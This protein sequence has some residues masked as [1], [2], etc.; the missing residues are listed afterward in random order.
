MKPEEIKTRELD[1]KLQ[2]AAVLKILSSADVKRPKVEDFDGVY[3]TKDI[4]IDKEYVRTRKMRF[5]RD[6]DARSAEEADELAYL[7]KK[8]DALETLTISLIESSNWLGGDVFTHQTTDYDDIARGVDGV[9]EFDPKEIGI[10]LGV[11]MDV[12]MILGSNPVSVEQIADAIESNAR[13]FRSRSTRIKYFSPEHDE[14]KGALDVIPVV[15]GLDRRSTT[16]IFGLIT[17]KSQVEEKL[18]KDPNNKILKD[19]LPKI[20]KEI[21][22][23]PVQEVIATEII[24]QLEAYRKIAEKESMDKRIVTAI[25]KMIEIIKRKLKSVQ[26]F[27]DK[28]PNLRND[29]VLS[30]IIEE[31][32]RAL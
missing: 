11:G 19:A 30:M 15:V 24:E 21:E 1:Q 29:L 9:L 20:S 32:H 6:L 13:K 3:S 12:K 31:S 7:K 4:A 2:R 14:E 10:R 23:S 25:N 16:H 18:A 8:S 17:K 22:N 5:A 28:S 26:P 27:F